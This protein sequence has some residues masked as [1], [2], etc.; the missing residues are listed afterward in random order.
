MI[1][2]LK[3]GAPYRTCDVLCKLQQVLVRS[4]NYT[5]RCKNGTAVSEKLLFYQH[6]E[7]ALARGEISGWKGSDHNLAISQVTGC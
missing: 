1:A 3:T 7:M 6:R 5:V 4:R 2:M